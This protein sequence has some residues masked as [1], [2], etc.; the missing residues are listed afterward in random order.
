MSKFRVKV[1]DELE[2]KRA[3]TIK[4]ASDVNPDVK[5]LTAGDYAKERDMLKAAGLGHAIE[6]AEKQTGLNI[7]RHQFE[8][9]YSGHKVFQE[10]EIRD[11]CIKYDLRLRPSKDYKGPVDKELG[12]KLNKFFEDNNLSKTGY[13]VDC[14]YIMAP[15]KVFNLKEKPKPVRRPISEMWDP[16]LLYEIPTRETGS[17]KTRRFVFIHHWGNDF[18]ILRYL[19]GLYTESFT[20][21]F[22]ITFSVMFAISASIM[23]TFFSTYGGLNM[24][25]IFFLSVVSSLVL[26]IAA[27][28]IMFG[29]VEQNS[30]KFTENGWES[31]FE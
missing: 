19:R 4:A 5:L 31:E 7:E 10:D 1:V 28:A 22:W 3:E 27:I 8:E 2:E 25:L 24:F 15:K 30:H 6:V 21:A 17:N 29:E 18:T 13:D 23:P 20:S 14:L 9:Q 11:L 26:S 12:T 16:V